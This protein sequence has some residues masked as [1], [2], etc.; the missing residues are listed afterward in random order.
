MKSEKP[1]IT[2]ATIAKDLSL[3]TRTVASVLNGNSSG[4]KIAEQTVK[5]VKDYADKIGFHSNIVA[6]AINGKY[7]KDV[8]IVT[9]SSNSVAEQTVFAQ[10]TEY[11]VVND[12]SFSVAYHTEKGFPFLAREIELFNPKKVVVFAGILDY[13]DYFEQWQKVRAS[14]L[15]NI[16]CF[17]LHGNLY[18]KKQSEIFMTPG[19]CWIRSDHKRAYLEIAE[20]AREKGVK[21]VFTPYV[22]EPELFAEYG[23]ETIP[24]KRPDIGSM[25]IY[26]FLV[27]TGKYA[28]KQLLEKTFHKGQTAMLFR[29]DIVTCAAIRYL[30]SKGIKA[31]DDVLFL[32]YDYDVVSQLLNY[33]FMSWRIPH[34]QMQNYMIKWIN[35]EYDGEK[36]R[37]MEVKKIE[38]N[39]ESQ[40]GINQNSSESGK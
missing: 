21:Y 2:I 27:E 34:K 4:R 35:D 19:D 40:I 13:Y 25:T 24:L 31:Q 28:A 5:R 12:I 3:S 33:A 32:S 29:N 30:S 16:P 8:I 38:H 11:L 37:L 18:G 36:S 10:L 6:L 20:A 14:Y 22:E 9:H 23:M 17:F 26:E 7:R 1:K 15:K 39:T